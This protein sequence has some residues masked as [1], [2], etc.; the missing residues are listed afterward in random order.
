MRVGFIG[1]G[2]FANCHA[3]SLKRIGA[4]I[5]GCYDLNAAGS[6]VF[7]QKH[8]GRAFASPEEL[9]DSK[10]IDCLY[11][12]IPPFARNGTHE[13]LALKKN[14]P[15]LC[16]KPLGLKLGPVLEIAREVEHRGFVSACGF[17][18]RYGET[19]ARVRQQLN[20]KRLSSARSC[21]MDSGG[22]PSGAW[23]YRE[24]ESGGWV[25]EMGVHTLDFMRYV[26][27][28]VESVFAFQSEG[29]LNA[30]DA[31]H[32]VYDSVSGTLKFKSGLVANLLVSG[33]CPRPAS[34]LDFLDVYGDDYRLHYE[35]IWEN[36]RVR[37]RTTAADWI[38]WRVESL[39]L[40]HDLKNQAFLTAVEKR[41]P[42]LVLDSY[43]DAMIS[44]AVALALNTSAKTGQVIHVEEFLRTKE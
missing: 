27:G 38:E 29:I 3:A 26:L 18:L 37:Y 25:M 41:D 21:R 20:G 22:A 10:W 9:V 24:S 1:T 2:N 39:D 17:L 42:A 14:I 8:G 35:N 16:E 30:R 13:K 33:V 43:P 7:A 44:T 6:A 40:R 23:A 4:E 32:H 31:R 15:F 11:V 28:E 19:A 5:T 12:V 34:H 36:C